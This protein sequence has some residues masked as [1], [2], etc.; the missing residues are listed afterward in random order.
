ME[1]VHYPVQVGKGVGSRGQKAW[2]AGLVFLQALLTV[3]RL[4]YLF[5][6]LGGFFMGLNVYLGWYALKKGLDITVVCLW[7]VI[8][9]VLM[10]YDGLGALSGIIVETFHLQFIKV[11]ILVALPL[12]HFL[13]ADFAWNLFKEHERSGG[14]FK[15]LFADAKT[16]EQPQIYGGYGADGQPMKSNK[17]DTVMNPGDVSMAPYD[18]QSPFQTGYMPQDHSMPREMYNPADG[19]ASRKHNT[20]CC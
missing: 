4:V 16:V 12:V 3:G 17:F 13:A 1:Y 15:P 11:G 7:G 19:S 18:K 20:A 8:S 2:M 5:E 10:I 9:A 6:T 14:F